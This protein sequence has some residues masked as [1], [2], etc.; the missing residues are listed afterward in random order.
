MEQDKTLSLIKRIVREACEKHGLTLNRVLLFGSRARGEHDN[1][2][3]YDLMVIVNGLPRESDRPK[4]TTAIN[5]KLALQKIPADILVKSIKEF[6]LG[7]GRIG[8]IT[9][10]VN[11]EGKRL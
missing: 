6:E 9:R 3:D 11:R 7:R 8:S 1:R 2:S 10:E 5:R 4:I